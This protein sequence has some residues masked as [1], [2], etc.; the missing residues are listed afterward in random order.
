ME[1]WEGLPEGLQ[2]PWKIYRAGE[3]IKELGSSWS[4]TGAQ[5]EG[6]EQCHRNRKELTM[7]VASKK[8]PKCGEK[9]L[10]EKKEELP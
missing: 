3:H 9:T 6:Q 8:G 10:T 4:G 2:S 7:E 1:V 5:S